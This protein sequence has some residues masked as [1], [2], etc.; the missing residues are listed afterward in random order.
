MRLCQFVAA[1]SSMIVASGG[2]SIV[3]LRASVAIPAADD[4]ARH[5]PCPSRHN[6]VASELMTSRHFP[7]LAAARDSFRAPPA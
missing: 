7:A 4:G 1:N 5:C 6:G 3:A 2:S